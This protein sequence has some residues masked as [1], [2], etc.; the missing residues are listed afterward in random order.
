MAV[1][2]EQFEDPNEINGV[3]VNLR[4]RTRVQLWTRT[5][6]DQATQVNPSVSVTCYHIVARSAIALSTGTT[7]RLRRLQLRERAILDVYEV[8]CF[9]PAQC[10]ACGCCC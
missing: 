9:D 4:G 5:A 2:G 10:M 6:D 3:V 1:V 7:G 8:P